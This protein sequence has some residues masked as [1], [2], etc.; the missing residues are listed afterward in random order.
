MTKYAH[1]KDGKV[2]RIKD[3][4]AEQ[5]AKI[6]DHK[7]GYILPV[8]DEPRPAF[9]PATHHGP[10]GYQVITATE[11]TN[12]WAAPVAKTPD[13]IDA[14]KEHMIDRTD[15]LQFKVLFKHENR[16]RVLEGKAKITVAQFRTALKAML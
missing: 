4:T 7:K 8:V 9:D 11:V 13:E 5:V 3:L 10:V 14:D 6:P 15:Q 16:I 2:W 12:T 1:I